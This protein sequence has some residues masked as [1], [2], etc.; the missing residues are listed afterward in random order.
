MYCGKL[1]NFGQS[2]CV[3]FFVTNRYNNNDYLKLFTKRA[4]HETKYILIKNK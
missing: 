4:D 3:E 2:N 1:G